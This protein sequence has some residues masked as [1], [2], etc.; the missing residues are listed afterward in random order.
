ME[1]KDRDLTLDPRSV[2]DVQE[3]LKMLAA[4]YTPEWHVDFQA[5]DV[6]ATLGLIFANQMGQTIQRYN[7]MLN[8][9][10]TEFVNMLGI[11]LL[12]A[13]PACGVV[14]ADLVSESISGVELG[15]GVQMIASNQG[16]NVVFETTGDIYV[17][18]SSLKHIVAISGHFGKI[19]PLRGGPSQTAFLPN[20]EK[21]TSPVQVQG[22]ISLFDYGEKGIEQNRVLFYHKTLFDIGKKSYIQVRLPSKDGKLFAY[23]DE[24]AFLW[25]YYNGITLVNFS[26]KETGPNQ[27]ELRRNQVSVP[28]NINGSAYD[29]I[30]LTALNQVT[31]VEEVEEIEM[32]SACQETDPECIIH[33]QN[34]NMGP[35]FLPFGDTASLFDECYIGH[36]GVFAQAGATV[37]M[38]C[39]LSYQEK[40]ITFYPQQEKENFKI[41]KRKPPNEHY[42]ML[43][44]RPQEITLEYFN[45]IGWRKLPCI[46][47]WATLFASDTLGEINIT[48][49]CP[50]DW[51]DVV[52]GG[53]KSKCV[54]LR[55]IRAD[56]C[57][58]QPCIH[59]MP[60]IN[61]LRL[62]YAYEHYMHPHHL[63]RITGT[64]KIHLNQKMEQGVGIDLFTPLPYRENALYLGF[65]RAMEQGPVSILFE[66]E[67][68]THF[69]GAPIGYFYSTAMGLR[70]LKV[71][72]N[73]RNM[74]ETGTLVFMP[75]SDFTP[76]EMEGVWGYWICMIDE[77]HAY[78]DA[79]NHHTQIKRIIPNAVEVR[80]IESR[81]EEAFYV[82]EAVANRSVPLAAENILDAEVFV[83]ER[84]SLSVPAMEQLME[85]QGEDVRAE[86]DFLGNI[87]SFFVRWKEVENFDQ[88]QSNDR[89]YCIDRMN[90]RIQF[91]DGIH[92][93]IPPV[94]SGVAFT[95]A[96]KSCRGEAGNVES[97]M[98]NT[99]VDRVLYL[100][101]IKNPIAT[102]GGSNIEDI[103]SAHRRGAN[104]VSSRNR[105]ITK[106]DFI[107]EVLTFSDSIAK[108]KCGIGRNI[109]GNIEPGVIAIAVMMKDYAQ[110]S[111]SFHNITQRLKKRL[112]SASEI[113][114]EEN[115]IH[116][117]EPLY[118]EISLDIWVMPT[119]TQRSFDVQNMI[120]QQVEGF[121][122]PLKNECGP[123]WEMGDLP[124][125]NELEM[126][127]RAIRGPFQ[128]QRFIPTVQYVDR[129]GAHQCTL[130]SFPYHEFAI[131]ISGKH[132]IYMLLPSGESF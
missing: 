30:C 115:Q 27:V 39:S 44:T 13:H 93:A 38:T 28:L 1:M 122:N 18:A 61:N 78:N 12:P 14:V 42:Q 64:N 54:R 96:V 6:G 118:I 49:Q 88:S 106:Q 110:G 126:M 11:S 10:Q 98:V 112:V 121:L 120:L 26:V 132:H 4:S 129:H 22:P 48:F 37:S 46:S 104:M 47:D 19:I 24:T 31:E 92:V 89:H 74:I 41:I 8:K 9:C 117:M 130:A 17:T 81:Q 97:G 16:E 66:I 59:V 82:T 43:K 103:C 116:L 58:L 119:D 55:I 105:L 35:S 128:I 68:I 51:K 70:P 100:N 29:L 75:P 76:M 80:N 107:R 87:R 73:T 32:S 5:P 71:I 34:D 99:L 65:D 7:Q 125:E 79:K 94:Q 113:T 131:G 77:R 91:G 33:N 23:G 21:D 45:G 109:D 124:R 101:Q 40:L 102:F 85:Q 36:N 2:T 86:F 15:H 72:D 123:G 67:D 69:R 60:V 3:E 90:N 57:Y 50:Q 83:S 95:V 62:S 127:L 52:V 114:L 108:A 20:K 111:Y 53:Y 25:Q 84:T 56:N 63:Y